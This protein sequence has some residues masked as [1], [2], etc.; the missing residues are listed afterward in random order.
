[1]IVFSIIQKSQLEGAKRLD[2][3]YYQ[4]EYLD[5]EKKFAKLKIRVLE[6]ISKSI[7]SFGAY[8]LTSH[9]EWQK[10]G[11]P[12]INVGD[13]HD[14]YIDFSRV[15]YISEKVSGILKKSKVSDG[16]VLL[17]IAGTIGNAAVAHNFSQSVNANQAIAKITLNNVVSPYYLT[18]FLNSKYGLLQTRREIVSSVQENIFLG[19]I[20]KFK[21]PIF[22]R[23]ITDKIE[24]EYRSFLEDLENS[25]L[26]YQQAE[27]LLL[28]ELKIGNASKDEKLGF[29]VNL[30]DIKENNRC[31]AEYFQPK[32]KKIAEHI[33]KN[34]GGVLLGD[35]VEIKKG[36]EPGA[37]AYLDEGRQF[38]RVSS[39]SKF[40]IKDNDQKCLSEELYQKL[41]GDFEPQKGEILLT[42]DASP[43]I[44]YVL[45]ENIEG[46]IAG[47]ILRLK[48]KNKDIEDEYLAL[49]VNSIVGRMQA[50][51]D[52]GGS[53]IAHWK[54]DQI[55]NMSIPILPKSIQ[56]KIANLICQAHE[57][58]KK[59][60][61]LLEE[62][63]SKVEK[64]IE[65]GSERWVE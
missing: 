27:D 57:T 65:N 49:C 36:V 31:D 39:L 15:K 21:I 25:K 5:L 40:G 1:M 62:A 42:K 23:Q 3:E 44:A 14:G 13:I 20:K 34:C 61:E 2:A 9:I 33:K 32:Y 22:N 47:G 51:R 17:S 7:V 4:P 19:P 26:L 37:E 18:A 63:K 28:D 30:S 60:K 11:V 55:K 38:I 6:E 56:Q 64:L 50:E 54:P 45:K 53:V 41:K 24:K 12:Y 43:G 59:A 16:Q 8:S 10:A 48:L 58:R 46:I 35:L 29:M 52:A